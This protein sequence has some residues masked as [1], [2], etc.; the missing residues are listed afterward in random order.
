MRGPVSLTVKGD[1]DKP[2]TYYFWSQTFLGLGAEELKKDILNH[3]K[4]K[5]CQ[6]CPAVFPDAAKNVKLADCKEAVDN[7]VTTGKDK[8]GDSYADQW[9]I[10]KEAL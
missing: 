2:A 4:F 6:T 7:E 5:G 3:P 9:K 10:L 1:N 8:F